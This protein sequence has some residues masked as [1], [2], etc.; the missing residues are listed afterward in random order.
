MAATAARGVITDDARAC[1]RGRAPVV[2]AVSAVSKYVW[3]VIGRAQVEVAYAAGQQ[4]LHVQ[5]CGCRAH[6]FP[7]M[8]GSSQGSGRGGRGAAGA[9]DAPDGRGSGPG[10][11]H[12]TWRR[13]QDTHPTPCSQSP[14]HV[15]PPSM[16]IAVQC[17]YV[18]DM[19]HPGR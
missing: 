12:T 18:F 8:E 10:A 16:G 9:A 5:A 4:A 7:G 14:N 15:T 1:R 2:Y 6:W 3:L 13:A 19:S 17:I 11:S